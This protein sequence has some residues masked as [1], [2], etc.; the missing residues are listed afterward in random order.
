MRLNHRLLLKGDA[1]NPMAATSFS[2]ATFNA[3]NLLHSGVYF[4]GR[5]DKPYTKEFY[6]EKLDWIVNVLHEGGPG[7]VGMQELFSRE[8]F[9]SIAEKA[10]YAFSYAPDIE[11]NLNITKDATG[12]LQ[13]QGPYNGLLS[14]YPILSSARIKDFPSEVSG[15]QIED[16]DGDSE[17]LRL[18][19]TSFQ[20]P[21]IQV[22]VE[23]KEGV[24]ATVFVAHLKSKRPIYLASE[25]NMQSDPIIQACGRI[26]SLIVRAAESVALRQLVVTVMKNSSKPVILFGDLNDDLPSVTT[27]TIAGEEPFRYLSPAKKKEAWDVFLYS[28]HDIEE[29]ESYRD[30]S[31]TNIYNGRYELLD[32]IFVS[33]EFYHRN[34]DCIATVCN[35]R[36]FNDHLRDERRVVNAGS[37]PSP[38]SDHGIPVT[39][40]TWK[41]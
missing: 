31:Y 17:P 29:Q 15:I 28:V 9:T 20:R 26:R 27:Q 30:V 16:N 40:I 39:E 6:Q 24:V 32:H 8:A 23:L 18:S 36:I 12:H 5:N 22:D 34:P 41:E 7:L 25:K 13:A 11:S 38:K 4:S 1:S 21:V 10:G 14:R 2:I 33:Q 19:V 37:Y 35:T 3:Q